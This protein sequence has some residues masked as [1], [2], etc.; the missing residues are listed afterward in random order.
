[1]AA[2]RAN[3]PA[4]ALEPHG[5]CVMCHAPVNKDTAMTVGFVEAVSAPGPPT[6]ADDKCFMAYR[7]YRLDEHPQGNDG[8]PRYRDWQPFAPKSR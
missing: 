2:T 4:V 3:N 8:R 7:L 1:M 6:Y 5:W